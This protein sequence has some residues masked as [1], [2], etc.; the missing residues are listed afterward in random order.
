MNRARP[1]TPRARGS[2][3]A[4][5]LL[6]AAVVSA[7]A[8]CSD[9]ERPPFGP[10]PFGPDT[11][12]PTID[13][14][15]PPGSDS[16]FAPGSRILVR[17]VVRDRSPIQSVASGVLGVVVYGFETLFPDDTV[18][19]ADFPITTPAGVTGAITFRVVA[20]DTLGNRSSAD[21][22]FLLQ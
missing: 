19:D 8:A 9:P 17:V 6:G 13:F 12:P 2:V 1:G 7:A 4:A 14:L 10:F 20:T 11:F 3:A 22:H 15:A 5:L 16:V 21:R 18:L